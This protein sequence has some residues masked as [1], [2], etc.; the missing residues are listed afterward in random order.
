[1]WQPWEDHLTS[2]ETMNFV[3]TTSLTSCARR[4]AAITS[5]RTTVRSTAV[6]ASTWFLVPRRRSPSFGIRKV[7]SALL[8]RNSTSYRLPFLGI[9]LLTVGIVLLT[10]KRNSASNPCALASAHPPRHRRRRMPLCSRRPRRPPRRPRGRSLPSSS[11]WSSLS[12]CCL[13]QLSSWRCAERRER[14][15]LAGRPAAGGLVERS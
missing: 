9:V 15:T 11:V 14:R 7:A 10:G 2:N 6:L 12:C 1:M 4:K 5:P 3:R 8:G 13:W